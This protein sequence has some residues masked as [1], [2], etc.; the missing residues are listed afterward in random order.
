M[1]LYFLWHFRL[2]VVGIEAEA[3]EVQSEG[4]CEKDVQLVVVEGVLDE[5]R[6][7]TIQKYLND[8][9]DHFSNLMIDK[10]LPSDRELNIITN[11]L[12]PKLHY[13]SS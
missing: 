7:V 10:A 3:F 12:A 4:R 8:Q 1:E 2:F 11:S 5:F 13:I 9:S 6:V